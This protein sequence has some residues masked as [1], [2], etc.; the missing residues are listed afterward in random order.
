[1]SIYRIATPALAGIIHVR[2]GGSTKAAKAARRELAEAHDL[3]PN[4]VDFAEVE[5]RRGKAGLVEYLNG[6]HAQ[7]PEEYKPDGYATKAVAKKKKPAKKKVV[8]AKA[9][10]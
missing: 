6:F 9:K 8:K 4:Q 10:K 1:M 3:K 7:L 5:T 2:W